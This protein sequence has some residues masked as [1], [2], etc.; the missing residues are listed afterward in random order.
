MQ[1][2]GK[3]KFHILEQEEREGLVAYTLG[4]SPEDVWLQDMQSQQEGGGAGGSVTPPYF[5]QEML[6]LSLLC[7]SFNHWCVPGYRPGF[8]P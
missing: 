6:L 2:L 8:S 7:I 5:S 1:P 3:E 4:L